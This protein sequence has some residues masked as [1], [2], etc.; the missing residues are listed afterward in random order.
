[1]VDAVHLLGLDWPIRGDGTLDPPVAAGLAVQ[2]NEARL[3]ETAGGQRAT[4]TLRITARLSTAQAEIR[5]A[6]TL[7]LRRSAGSD[8]WQLAPNPLPAGAPRP[9]LHVKPAD[10]STPLQALALEAG[11]LYLRAPQGDSTGWRI[12]ATSLV[13]GQRMELGVALP[14]YALLDDNA[15]GPLA[16]LG[17]LVLDGPARATEPPRPRPPGDSLAAEPGL[18][19]PLVRIVDGATVIGLHATRGALAAEV[20]SAWRPA[21]TSGARFEFRTVLPCR[22]TDLTVAANADGRVATLR[23]TPRS[24]AATVALHVDSA[25]PMRRPADVDPRSNP[26]IAPLEMEAP[27]IVA[28]IRRGTG[29]LR[30]LSDLWAEPLRRGEA[31]VI[32]CHGL[33][34]PQGDAARIAL[35][36]NNGRLP[37]ALR[38]ALPLD[39][40]NT[41]GG[42]A[43]LHLSALLLRDAPGAGE[44]GRIEVLDPQIL[45]QRARAVLHCELDAMEAKAPP[46][47]VL[48]CQSAHS[49]APPPGADWLVRE[50]QR[51][52]TAP[53]IRLGGEPDQ[54]DADAPELL[55]AKAGDSFRPSGTERGIVHHA[56]KVGRLGLPLVPLAVLRTRDGNRLDAF[57]VALNGLVGQPRYTLATSDHET[58]LREGPH[59]NGPQ[60]PLQALFPVP[61]ARVAATAPAAQPGGAPPPAS[62]PSLG[63]HWLTRSYGPFSPDRDFA[64]S[65]GQP[66]A[67]PP[68]YL[69]L[70][71]PQ[72]TP[73]LGVD[74]R[75]ELTLPVGA[76]GV[77]TI[78]VDLRDAGLEA[79]AGTGGKVIGILKI[80]RRL[81]LPAIFATEAAAGRP[82]PRRVPGALD[83][84]LLDRIID[85]SVKARGW[86]GLILFGV[87][88]QALPE[89]LQRFMPSGLVLGYLAVPPALRGQ[90]PS[91]AARLR[92]KQ[93]DA[94]PERDESGEAFFRPISADIAWADG[95]LRHAEIEARLRVRAFLG[96]GDAA[97]PPPP[98]AI[99]GSFDAERNELRFSGRFDTPLDLLPPLV[100][101]EKRVIEQAVLN[102]LSVVKADDG[103]WLSVDGEITPGEFH[104]ANGP[105]DIPRLGRSPIT[106][107]GLRLQLPRFDISLPWQPTAFRYPSLKLPLDAKPF[108]FGPLRLKLDWLGLGSG[109]DLT[110]YIPMWSDWSAGAGD[111]CFGLSLELMKLPELALKSVDRL[112]IDLAFRLPSLGGGLHRNW[113]LNDARIGLKLA[114]FDGLNIDLLRFIVLKADKVRFGKVVT[115]EKPGGNPWIVFTGVSLSVAGFKVMENLALA[116]FTTSEGKTG[117][118]GWLGGSDAAS[119]NLMNLLGCDWLLLG[120]NVTLREDATK[121]VFQ[122]LLGIE[123]LLPGQ[124]QG[125]DA[126]PIE[127]NSKDFHKFIGAA[128]GANQDVEPAGEGRERAVI[129]AN[130]QLFIPDPG[131]ANR[132][133]WFFGA[134]VNFADGL[135]RGKALFQDR[136]YYGLAL[137]GRMFDF[138]FDAPFAVSIL[139]QKGDV[140]SK[141]RFF[142]AIAVPSFTL[143]GFSFRGGILEATV[144]M[145]GDFLFDFGFPRLDG[146]R[147]AWERSFGAIVGIL[148]GSGGVYLG[149]ARG[150]EVK[151]RLADLVAKLPA[152]AYSPDTLEAL[153]AGYG[154]QAGFG[155][156]FN[157]GVVKAF[158][159]IGLYLVCEGDIV[160][161][162]QA[163]GQGRR[164]LVALRVTGAAGVLVEA[165]AQLDWWIISVRVAVFATAEIRATLTWVVVT[166]TIAVDLA[167]DLSARVSASACIGA[168]PFK[169][170]KGIS[171][172]LSMPVRRSFTLNV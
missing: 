19:V 148:Q 116:V 161:A 94:Q 87:P 135:L 15:T 4:A 70:R 76:D 157:A 73:W 108:G 39:N 83:E 49:V 28:V 134:G 26:A 133:S 90:P 168:G 71:E 78:R 115:P 150:G 130:Q 119:G 140:P 100:G 60:V 128:F 56:F 127:R 21:A 31:L 77:V 166:K 153:S 165:Q 117:F 32:T 18:F 86:T 151:R 30:R 92:W 47:G 43:L 65:H 138:L 163:T 113:N 144:V 80:S 74:Q 79:T 25:R 44:L 62:R 123:D 46:R 139:Y 167:F 162:K 141:D 33:G 156:T 103:V 111:F 42:A 96:L 155:A 53:Q 63:D 159:R 105:I 98:L 37:L 54:R 152:T 89:M 55:M 82:L 170:C 6:G 112:R 11:P 23:F 75:L 107:T 136:R 147:R 91:I 102:G 27:Q 17:G 67:D 146:P 20:G 118:V 3:T 14:G 154:V 2:L 35:T 84:D 158:A 120:Q 34:T 69:V 137:G 36:P 142:C 66:A 160:T 13:P 72:Q 145:D 126:D 12:G 109:V 58:R 40:P 7:A 110:G 16:I 172:S 51:D 10:N 88:V 85:P 68:D 121:D 164:D 50:L 171:V 81:D 59:P 143:T 124:P 149:R 122:K 64:V 114:G 52:A 95:K 24:S 5:I 106:F 57:A 41:G 8:L 131:S 101:D 29:Q 129:K 93:A 22:P 61:L 9:L 132:E 104:W 45:E 125:A 169:V 38:P 1:M 97:N 48:A 99:R